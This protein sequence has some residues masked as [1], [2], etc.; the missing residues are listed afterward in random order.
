MKKCIATVLILFNTCMA[1]VTLATDP[2][3]NTGQNLLPMYLIVNA[4]PISG[5][6]AVC[7]NQT[8]VNYDVAPLAGTIVYNWTVPAGATIVS[9]QGSNAIVVNFGNTFGN[10]CVTADD[11]TGPGAPSCLNTFAAP[12][13]PAQPS[14]INGPSTTVC[15]GQFITYSVAADPLAQTYHWIIPARMTLISGAGTN[16]I[17]ILVD[18]GFVWGYLRVSASNCRG[19]SGQFVIG[20]YS[21]PAKPGSVSGPQVGACPNG[22]YTYSFAPVPGATSYTWYAPPG[23]VITSP[24]A[25]GN[26]LTTNVASVDITFPANFSFGTLYIAANSGCNSSELREMQIRSLPSKPGGI[27]GPF[28]GVC[29]QSNVMYTLDSVPGATSYTWSFS[30]SALTIINGNGNDTVYV[31]YLPGFDHGT[32]C[33][34]ANDACGSSIARCGVVFARP[35]TPAYI[36]GPIGACNT[37]PASA[38]AY[39]SVDS[40]FGVTNYQWSVPPGA[41]IT[42]GQGTTDITVNYMGASNGN[43]SVFTG[44]ACGTSQVR[45]LS[46]V[47]NNCR[48]NADGTITIDEPATVFP[49]PATDHATVQFSSNANEEYTLRLL[50]ITGREIY[51]V[52][53]EAVDGTNSEN[54]DLANFP[55]GIYMVELITNGK[56]ENSK[57]I[58]R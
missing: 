52:R 40:I 3:N 42:A 43:V 32:F 34:T 51:S 21:A 28:Y 49:N 56:Q 7:V 10:I 6:A 36:D 37:I 53:H 2:Q 9:G 31:D 58:V 38:I 44:N 25:S 35:K 50:D 55:K 23:C 8:N 18:S 15:P 13:R 1:L 27:H 30:S 16:S 48:M 46:I 11:G 47:V 41:T 4:G 39:Y 12:T 20:V 5:P 29:G 22:T 14:A 26:P 24:V 19:T 17:V 33:V 45:S 54:L 57:L